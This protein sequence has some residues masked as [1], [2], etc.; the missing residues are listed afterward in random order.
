MMEQTRSAWRLT[1]F[2]HGSVGGWA[3]LPVLVFVDV[4]RRAVRFHSMDGFD[5]ALGPPRLRLL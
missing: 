2:G 3:A 5:R 4:L 1:A